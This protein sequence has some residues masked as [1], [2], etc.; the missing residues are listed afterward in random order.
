[1]VACSWN[2]CVYFACKSF[3]VVCCDLYISMENVMIKLWFFREIFVRFFCGHFVVILF[4]KKMWTLLL[5]SVFEKIF[6]RILICEKSLCNI[7]RI[8]LF[9]IWN[10]YV[11]L[12]KFVVL[13]KKPQSRDLTNCFLAST[14]KMV[15]GPSLV[16][17]GRARPPSW[18]EGGLVEY[19]NQFGYCLCLPGLAVG[20][21]GW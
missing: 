12:P 20:R 18:A 21:V 11:H 14:A 13:R 2:F 1:M 15:L 16:S 4:V 6:L 9:F 17:K 5:N 3:C 7:S 8:M 10:N 19:W